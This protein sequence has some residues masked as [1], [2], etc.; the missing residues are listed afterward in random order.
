MNTFGHAYRMTLLGESHGRGVGVVLDG[1][2]P[3]IPLSPDDVQPALDRRKPGKKL[4]SSRR[5]GDRV[6]ILSG[7]FEGHTTGAPVTMWIDNRDVDSSTYDE[8]LR[9]PR[10]GHADY[11]QRVKY[12]GHS[13][14]R[15]GGRFSGR[16]TAG[17]VMAGAVAEQ[18]LAAHDVRVAAHACAIG[19]VEAPATPTE[20]EMAGRWANDVRCAFPD[21]AE[22]MAEQIKDA[23]KAKDSVGGVVECLAWGLP[24]GLGE[25]WFD[26]VEAVM[27]HLAFSI[28]ACRGIEFGA[29]FAQARMR[30]SESND[31]FVLVE[32]GDD[33]AED[34]AEGT[35]TGPRVA[36]EGNHHGGA[37]GGI[38]TGM[39]L[40]FRIAFKPPASIPTEQRTVDLDA[41]EEDTVRILGRH[42]PCI[43]PRAVPVVEAC[44]WTVL[45]D[46]WLR[47]RGWDVR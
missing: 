42:D 5:E 41:M 14:H 18:A 4:T 23:L 19:D 36:T 1:V 47:H 26:D 24:A 35:D 38:T 12:G 34:R 28:P 21:A 2:P 32:P 44:C 11:T 33:G 16:L 25:P 31:P 20:E 30:G 9:K 22:A 27:A 39:P 6:E 13:D 3:G 10:P 43:V 17:M 40:H 37:L 7:V 29:G 15:G 8:F 45:F 46:L